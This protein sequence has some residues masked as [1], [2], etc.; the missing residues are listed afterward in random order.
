MTIAPSKLGIDIS[1]AWLDVFDATTGSACRLANRSADIQSFLAMLPKGSRLVFEATGPYDTVLRQCLNN[2]D[3]VFARLNPARVRDFAR[4]K[5]QLAKT[6]A[7]DA[8]ML[9]MM[10]DAVDLTSERAFDDD[11]EALAALHRRR[12]QLVEQRAVERARS[13]DAPDPRE[14]ESLKRHMTFLDGEIAV[15]EADIDALL[16]APALAEQV[17]ILRSLKGVGPVTAATL[18]ALL[19]ELGSLSHK[20]IAALAGLAPL[21][22]DSGRFRGQRHVRGGRARVRRALYMAAINAIR[23]VPRFKA[24][25]TAIVARSGIKKVGIVAVAR[26]LLV[27]LNAMMRDGKPFAA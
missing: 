7:I 17:V 2:A 27:T 4:F 13:A 10:A 14:R 9:A 23:V 12:D 6:D 18:L 3:L 1:K 21:N 22:C 26:K 8:R 16:R 5:G 20:A 19:P 25:Y 11:R 24:Q 15:V